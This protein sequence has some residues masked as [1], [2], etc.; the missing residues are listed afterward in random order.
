MQL[1]A[2]KKVVYTIFVQNQTRVDLRLPNDK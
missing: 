1:L 2:G